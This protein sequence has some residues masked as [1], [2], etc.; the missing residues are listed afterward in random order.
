MHA[1]I[2]AFLYPTRL[3]NK[4]F[5]ALHKLFILAPSAMVASLTFQIAAGNSVS[6][7]RSIMF[8]AGLATLQELPETY[9]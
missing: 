4:L 7:F 3:L 2:V 6:I 9:V 5:Q 8:C 1:Q